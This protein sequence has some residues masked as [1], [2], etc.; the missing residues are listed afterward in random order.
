MAI[1]L[2]TTLGDIL[3][4]WIAR[5]KKR[6][7]EKEVF[8]NFVDVLEHG[9]GK[10]RAYN[11]PVLARFTAY[12]GT[13]DVD[14]GIAESWGDTNAAFTPTEHV[15][16]AVFTKR[17]F[18]VNKEP[19]LA[20]ANEGLSDAMAA[21]KDTQITALMDPLDNDEGAAGQALQT[22]LIFQAKANVVANNNATYGYIPKGPGGMMFFAAHPLSIF[23]VEDDIMG[24]ASNLLA[25]TSPLGEFAAQVFQKGIVTNASGRQAMLPTIAGLPLIVSA[26]IAVDANDDASNAVWA[27][28][29]LVLVESGPMMHYVDE[30]INSGRA[31]GITL[32]EWYVAAE[33]VGTWGR[34]IKADAAAV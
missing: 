2:S 30:S 21:R 3:P 19:V 5:A 33:R 12:P 13:E 15:A 14:I 8:R 34:E 23:D 28:D 29:A 4:T 27:R 17:T 1:N 22:S 26:N 25:A 24:I 20:R 11:E 9:P 31:V 18:F 6:E 32:H 16:Q 10:G 7:Q